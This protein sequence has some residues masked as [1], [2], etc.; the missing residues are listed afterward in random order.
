MTTILTDTHITIE[1]R[2]TDEQ[3]TA[4]HL[5]FCGNYDHPAST[6]RAR[7][8]LRWPRKTVLAC[9]LHMANAIRSA[10]GRYGLGVEIER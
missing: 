1:P 10:T 2:T 4:G 9:D 3:C 8:I 5:D 6:T 7:W